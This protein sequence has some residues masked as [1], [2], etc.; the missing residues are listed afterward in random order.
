MSSRTIDLPTPRPRDAEVGIDFPREWIEF[1]DPADAQRLI[2]ADLTWL[3][4]RWTCIYGAGCQGIAE[5]RPDDGCCSHG[6]F[7]SDDDDQKRVAAAVAR[8][9]PELWQHQRRAFRLW[10]ARDAVGDEQNRLRT[11]RRNGACVFLNEA[12]F[13]GGAGCALHALALAEGVHPMTTKPDVCWQLPVRRV[14]EWVTR[15][16]DSLVLV[17]SL[18]EY[19]RRGWGSGGDDLNWWCT[20]AP[21]AHIGT[22]AVYLTYAAELTALIGAPAYAELARFCAVREAAGLTAPHPASVAAAAA[23]MTPAPAP[24]PRPDAPPVA[25][26]KPLPEPTPMADTK[27][28]AVAKRP[29]KTRQVAGAKA[30][31]EPKPSAGTKPTSDRTRRRRPRRNGRRPRSGRRRVR[32]P[33]HR[34]KPGGRPDGVHRCGRPAGQ[35]PGRVQASNL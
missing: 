15:P 8:L 34:G 7:F 31:R 19:D 22:E 14:Q 23:G 21:E 4:S 11:A 5:G 24:T 27:P 2:R 29:R 20:S 26:A 1:A 25:D 9:T 28:V 18:A 13:E 17:D 6:A 33:R 30:T 32:P 35:S 3:L 10:M 16:D 12:G